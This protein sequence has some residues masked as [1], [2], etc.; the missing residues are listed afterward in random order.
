MA[1]CSAVRFVLRKFLALTEMAVRALGRGGLQFG[2][3]AGLDPAI[4]LLAKRMDP[5]VNPRIKSGDAGDERDE[6]VRSKQ[7]LARPVA[8]CW[9]DAFR[10]RILVAVCSL[11]FLATPAAAE[12]YE[13]TGANLVTIVRGD[14]ISAAYEQMHEW[15]P[16]AI[17]GNKFD[18]WSSN[19]RCGVDAWNCVSWWG[20]FCFSW[21]S[22]YAGL[23]CD[24]PNTS[25]LNG[26]CLSADDVQRPKVRS[27][28]AN[29][30]DPITYLPNM[31]LEE[32]GNPQENVGDPLS[33]LVGRATEHEID[34]ATAGPYPLSFERFY[35]RY[36]HSL[37]ASADVSRLG[38]GWRSNFDALMTLTASPPSAGSE[39]RII[40]PDG[41]SLSF[42]YQNGA[43][44][45]SY[46]TFVAGY[47]FLPYGPRIGATE[48]LTVVGGNYHLRTDD[49]RTWI[50]DPNGKLT[51]IDYR[52]GY[53][54]TLYY[55]GG[56]NTSVT[57][58]LGRSLSFAYATSGLL[59]GV[60]APDGSVYTYQYQVKLE[61][62]SN[63]PSFVMDGL[64]G[65]STVLLSVT[66]PG[67]TSPTRTYVYDDTTTRTIGTSSYLVNPFGLTGVIDERGVRYA[68]FGY[69]SS[70]NAV[71]SQHVGGVDQ[72]SL[73]YD[74]TNKNV[75]VTN[76]LGKQSIWSF[77]DD[78]NNNRLLTSIQGQ[79]SAHCPLSNS[80]I[81]YDGN[82][83]I[84]SVTDEEGRVTSY[85]NNT[86]G[87]PTSITRGA[88]T[89]SAVTTTYSW[90]AN[91]RV[92]SEIVK[93]GRTTDFNYDSTTGR[94]V[95]LTQIDTTTQTVP[96]STNGQTR[97]W[98]FG[99]TG[100]L[101]TSVTGPIAGA[102]VTYA[103]D[104]NNFVHTIT[105][106]VGHVLTVS[107]VNGR[108]QPTVVVDANN[109]TTNL[110]YD[111]EG[112][113]TTVT[114]NPGT[115]QAV[116]G[117]IYNAAGDITKI[118]RPNGA[119][120]QYT[121]D[122]SRRL[123]NIQDNTGASIALTRNAFGDITAR[124]IK[125]PGNTVVLAQTAT[126]D[127]LGRL[128][129]FVGS[130]SQ[131]WTIAYDKTNSLVSVTDPRSN[132]QGQA[133]DSLSRLIRQTDEESQ[134]VNLTRDG[135]DKVTAYSDPRSLTTSYVRDGFGEV[136]QRTSPDTGTTV[137]TYSAAG[138]VT[139]IT[140]G[141]GVVTNLTYDNAGRLLTKQYPAATAENITITWDSTASGNYGVGRIT[142][143]DD[144]SGS[145][146]YT[147]N[148]LGQVTQETKTTASVVYTIA[149]AYDLAGNITQITYPSGRIVTYSRDAVGR[150][151][152]VTTK[153]DSGSATVTL[154]SGVAYEPFGPLASLTYG[155]G[156]ALTKTFTQD[157]LNNAL[158]VQD[159]STSTVVV[160]R[161]HAF[162][163]QI[164]L[165]G[166]T[167]QITSTRNESYIYTATN[168][169]QEGDGIWGTLTWGYDGV[170]N[171]SSEVLTSGGSTTTTYN[172]P[173]SSN[174]LS[175]VT[176]GSSTVRS[177]S[178]DGA[179][180]VTADS[181]SGTTYTYSYNNR[182]RLAELSIGSTVT[183]DYTYDGLERL[184]IRAT[185]N[186]TPA[187]TT[188]YVYD[189][190]GHLIA[191][192]S[193]TGTT[194]T[195]YV[196]L[197]D[198]PLAVVANVDT[199]TPHLYFVHADHL[200]RPIKM[201]DSTEAIVWDAV[202][203]PFGDVYSIS[204][205]AAN[206]LRFPGQYFLIEDGLHYN[207][208]RHYD[209]TLG[210]YLEADPL[211]FIDGPGLYEYVK[212]NPVERRDPTGRF[213]ADAAQFTELFGFD[214]CSDSIIQVGAQSVPL[215]C[216]NV[217]CGA[218]TAGVVYPLCPTC[219]NRL[220]NGG[221]PIKLENGQII[222]LPIEPGE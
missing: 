156:L 49:D 168:R 96:Y 135:Q 109:V 25:Y 52:G 163:D 185:Q 91:W 30:G 117:V 18:S 41:H 202:Y 21:G 173:T 5:R 220:K 160:N 119:Y 199:S 13:S 93:P 71:S 178:Y 196:W 157:Y 3:I 153:K 59:S 144:A 35:G 20:G 113:L 45:P 211:G 90:N 154:A 200:D 181:R 177:F 198:M 184:A 62:A 83:F 171:R 15:Y 39:A 6:S 188:H 126:F 48:T 44:V 159:T 105:D 36:Q 111:P 16:G 125:D 122:D 141:R 89:P 190:A 92:P 27:C 189:L 38:V 19:G 145:V 164:N 56:V 219:N 106:E 133:F 67:P 146:Q 68:T 72:Y 169:L 172:Y 170:G 24:E 204:G 82:A 118:T 60:T 197:D 50:F 17:A 76:P 95:S 180:N 33:P 51:E 152:G 213:A 28:S 137:Y 129:T 201:T 147:Y 34:F 14:C 142:E 77:T 130:G 166:I 161:S 8:R 143:I 101:L 151:S 75:T 150:I 58:N 2:V 176:Q 47:G 210:R 128:L 131:T 174:Q 42:L 136:I 100:I 124:T 32:A 9:F 79:A 165:T 140:D 69:D 1:G 31:T 179:G 121:W 81:T 215:F 46:L 216:Q 209:P 22:G 99:Y 167:D 29:V 193:G 115:N 194:V 148:V 138:K 12:H 123:T 53:V 221:P 120:L 26:H 55:A 187:G 208:Y 61:G 84:A 11:L 192:A 70:G 78:T 54:Q 4:H 207:W 97:T 212:G 186:M 112:R 66:E 40:L 214:P 74:A 23:V 98:T 149:Y 205:T 65:N 175:T 10:G 195:E 73:S 182:G 94:L 218:P 37:W 64:V 43:F 155:N 108:G 57:D 85:V 203:R 110:A 104:A 162:G 183:A 114:V 87:L 127:E 132:V 116:T 107:T 7:A 217:L 134:Q 139:Q 158:Q 191:E 206:N 103:Y 88:G 63:P 222:R 86:R 102:T 80:T